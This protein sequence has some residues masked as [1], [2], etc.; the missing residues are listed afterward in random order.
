MRHR[1][2]LRRRFGHARKKNVRKG[3]KGEMHEYEVHPLDVW[4]NKKEGFSV[5]D[6]Y[7]SRGRISIPED[8]TNDEIIAAL[9]KEGF[10]NRNIRASSIG[11][12]GEP[13]YTLYVEYKPTAHPEYELRKVH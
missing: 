3:Y 12:D 11:I 10:I 1:R 9:K 2:A 4:G 8:A 6:V 13:G 7:P 5:N